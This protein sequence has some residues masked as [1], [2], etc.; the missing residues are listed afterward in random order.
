[1]EANTLRKFYYPT[2]VWKDSKSMKI[3]KDNFSARLGIDYSI[4]PKASIGAIYS[5]FFADNDEKIGE[6]QIF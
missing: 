4:S 3:K 6:K 5:G 1:M 2:E